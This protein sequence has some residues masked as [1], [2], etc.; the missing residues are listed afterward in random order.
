MNDP[1]ATLEHIF[2]L[3]LIRSD[4]DV[5]IC[6]AACKEDIPVFERMSVTRTVAEYF[7]GAAATWIS[8]HRKNHE[9][10]DLVL[11]K[12][13][14]LTK[15]D[16]HEVEYLPL[17]EFE[18]IVE[19]IEALEDLSTLD[20]FSGTEVFIDGLR[21][22]SV[23]LTSQEKG[24]EP[25]KLFRFYSPKKELSRSKTFGIALKNGQYDQVEDS[26]FLFD[27]KFDCFACGDYL[28][29]KNKDAFQ[30]IFKF[31]EML[32]DAAHETLDTI[33]E[34]IPIDDFDA[35]SAAC[36]GHLQKLA[37]LKNIASKP[38]IKTLTIDDLK[39]VITTFKLPIQT[40]GEG[41]DE[42]LQFNVKDK[43]AILRLLDDDYLE[44]VMTGN[45]YEVNSK[46]TV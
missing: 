37:K 36:D 18:G 3:N 44:S 15:L 24:A 5:Q 8:K 13:E 32:K 34:H 20:P 30:K 40:I 35:F 39:Q 12:F 43:W 23:V 28:F 45:H 25:I 11:Q 27:D 14:V 2:D 17:A 41:D 21:F 26:L 6:L 9:Q 19:Q 29:I 31:Y 16:S 38:Y 42:K 4:V 33:E 1:A 46:R 7:Q 22:Y 10:A